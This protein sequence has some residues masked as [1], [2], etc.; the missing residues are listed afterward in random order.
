MEE[1]K[2]GSEPRKQLPEDSYS[3]YYWGNEPYDSSNIA[4]RKTDE[5]LKNNIDQNLRNNSNISSNQIEVYVNNAAVTLKG[6]VKTYEERR[7]AGQEAW[8]TSGV[9]KVLK[10]LQVL[11]PETAGPTKLSEKKS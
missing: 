8:N 5:E 4:G 9:V 11:E 1:Q 3:G 2:N 10:D 6:S 7:L